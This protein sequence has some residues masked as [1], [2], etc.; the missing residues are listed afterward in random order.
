[1]GDPGPKGC[2]LKRCLLVEMIFDLIMSCAYFLGCVFSYILEIKDCNN[3][4]R[5]FI[6]CFGEERF[7]IVYNHVQVFLP[8]GIVLL[9]DSS[10]RGSV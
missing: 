6:P 10:C 4:F 2:W 7:F 9:D 8:L 3:L 5:S 1:M